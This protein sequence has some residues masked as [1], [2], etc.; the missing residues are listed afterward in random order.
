M[1]RKQYI[2][3]LIFLLMPMQVFAEQASEKNIKVLMEQTGAA[4]MGLMMVNQLLPAL[5]KLTPKAP[6]KFWDDFAKDLDPNGLVD[7]IVPIYQ[8]YLTEQDVKELITFYNTRVGKKFLKLQ[9][10]M[11]KEAMI[12]GQAWGKGIATTILKKYKAEYE[13]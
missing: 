10:V 12:A 9:P 4:N 11:G 13:R 6:K 8:K 5:K 2:Y 7:L 1:G 3:G